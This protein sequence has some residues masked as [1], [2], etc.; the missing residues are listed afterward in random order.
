MENT[1]KDNKHVW[2]QVQKMKGHMHRVIHLMSDSNSQLILLK[3]VDM[4]SRETQ[5]KSKLGNLI[6]EKTRQH[7]FFPKTREIDICWIGIDKLESNF[8]HLPFW[9]NI[10][11]QNN[12]FQQHNLD[13]K[14][15][16]HLQ[17]LLRVKLKP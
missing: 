16:E 9:E 10:L 2:K 12:N 13:Y 1:S 3:V 5:N 7:I 4:D 6:L 8:P 17:P 15:L 11:Y 14:Q